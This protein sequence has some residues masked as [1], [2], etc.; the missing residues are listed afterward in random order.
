[1][2][3]RKYL[4]KAGIHAIGCRSSLNA[5]C[6]YLAPGSAHEHREILRALEEE[7]APFKVLVVEEEPPRPA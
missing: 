3:S 5:L 1:M 7:A 2:V 4:G 6:V